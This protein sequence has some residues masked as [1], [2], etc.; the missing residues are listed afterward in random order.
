MIPH[1]IR[2]YILSLP[3]SRC[4]GTC[5]YSLFYVLARV[6][7]TLGTS[8]C[9]MYC[10][11]P[12]MEFT[13]VHVYFLNCTWFQTVSVYKWVSE[14]YYPSPSPPSPYHTL[15]RRVGFEG[16]SAEKELF[17]LCVWEVLWTPKNWRRKGYCHRT[18]QRPGD[19]VSLWELKLRVK[20]VTYL[21]V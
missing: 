18:L 9:S 4:G 2:E 17:C 19:H 6:Y 14:D 10:V 1:G 3:L 13:L 15:H 16:G 20:P 7:Y 11:L 5:T 21:V 8:H 12:Y